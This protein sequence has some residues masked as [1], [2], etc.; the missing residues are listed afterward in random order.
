MNEKYPIGLVDHRRSPI[1]E[2]IYFTFDE[3]IKTTYA[4]PDIGTKDGYGL[5]FADIDE[6]PRTAAR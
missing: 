2:K 3:L 6:G 1:V 5:V 4:Q